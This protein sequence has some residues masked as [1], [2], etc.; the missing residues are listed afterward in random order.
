MRLAKLDDMGASIKDLNPHIFSPEQ[1]PITP[2]VKENLTQTFSKGTI[3]AEKELQNLCE[4]WLMLNGYLRRSTGDIEHAR[5]GAKY[6]VHLNEAKRNPILL[7]LLI[8]G[9][10]GRYIEIE[11][12]TATGRLSVE[13]SSIIL[14]SDHSVLVRDFESFKTAVT[15]WEHAGTLQENQQEGEVQCH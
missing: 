6:F 9:A 13:Q 5:E 11:L 15:I 4:S 2:E 1:K 8:M 10:D 14:N 3:K 12:K 7:D